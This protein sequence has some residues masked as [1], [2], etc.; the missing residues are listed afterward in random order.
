MEKRPCLV[1]F[2]LRGGG[3]HNFCTMSVKL[4]P[5]FIFIN[6]TLPQNGCRCFLL[7]IVD[8]SVLSLSVTNKT[9]PGAVIKLH[10]NTPLSRVF[11]QLQI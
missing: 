11:F 6:E 9:P 7:L 5:L 1:S 2:I 4:A 3:L 8:V 10:E